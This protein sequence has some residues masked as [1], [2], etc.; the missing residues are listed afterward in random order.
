MF[1]RTHFASFAAGALL[2]VLASAAHAQDASAPVTLRISAVSGSVMPQDFRAG[3][4]EG[5]FR[6]HGL[7][8]EIAELAT[9]A[10][11]ITATVNGSA[12]IGYADVFAG[13]SSIRNGFDI[14]FVAPHNG[15]SPHQF[16]LVRGDS[17]IRSVED[18]K[19]RNIALGAPPQFKAITSSW[20][21]VQGVDPSAVT[22]TIVPDQTTFGVLLQSGQA[23]AAFTSSAVNAY[24][25][26][27]EYGLRPVGITGSAELRIAEGSPIA[28]W[29]ATA[30]WFEAN[31]ELATRFRDALRE[32]IQW[33][34][35]LSAQ[36]KAAHVKEQTT[37]DLVALDKDLPGV[38][39]AATAYFG[40]GT[41]VDL[42]KLAAWVET[43]ARYADVPDDVDLDKHIFD[44][45]KN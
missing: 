13:L 38:L 23:D 12:D 18:L 11:N 30:E 20:L 17:D 35:S 24:R 15:P 8:I 21:A 2:A 27:S 43:G 9:G 45:A 22:F 33:Y 28:G 7:E 6:K 39:D 3:I 31:R 19:G 16:V 29:W 10:N 32:T 1:P 36:E 14:G 41:P 37:I 4:K 34:G 44:T 25:W 42:E 40:F 5:F 26:I